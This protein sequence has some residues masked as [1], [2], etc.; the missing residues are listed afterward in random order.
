MIDTLLTAVPFS[1]SCP[2]LFN[3]IPAE[4]ERW[5]QRDYDIL[6]ALSCRV[7]LVTLSQA[8]AIWWPASVPQAANRGLTKLVN[9]GLLETTYV[10]A[11][12]LKL[13]SR[14]LCSWKPGIDDPDFERLSDAARTRWSNL[15]QPHRVFYASRRCANL[16]GSSA[17]GLPPQIQRD[18]DL[19]LAQVYLFYRQSRP[20]LAERWIGEDTLDKAGYCQKDPDAFLIDDEGIPIRVIESS[21]RYGVKQVESF[22]DYCAQYDLSYELW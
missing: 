2:K 22:H 4:I 1:T 5:T 3:E 14:P 9:D 8:A 12:V 11:E 18:H 17:T 15:T 21:G 13:G 19:L 10:N 16:F 6:F 7:R 20:Q